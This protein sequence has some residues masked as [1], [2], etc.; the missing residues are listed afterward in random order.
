MLNLPTDMWVISV[1]MLNLP[2]DSNLLVI[3]ISNA[4]FTY[5]FKFMDKNS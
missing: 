2:T 3:S 5:E 1:G 4:K